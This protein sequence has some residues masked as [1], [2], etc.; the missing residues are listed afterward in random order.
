VLA[1]SGDFHVTDVRRPGKLRRRDGSLFE[2]PAGP[3]IDAQ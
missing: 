2:G 3:N 1:A